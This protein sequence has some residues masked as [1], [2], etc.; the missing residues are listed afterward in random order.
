MQKTTKTGKNFKDI[1][2]LISGNTV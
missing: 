2:V 1:S